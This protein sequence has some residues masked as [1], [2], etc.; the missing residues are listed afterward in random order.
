[1][2]FTSTE[3]HIRRAIE[4]TEHVVTKRYSEAKDAFL[5]VRCRYVT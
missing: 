2:T 1:M 5:Q 4:K 3:D